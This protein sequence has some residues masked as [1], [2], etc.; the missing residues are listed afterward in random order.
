L[1]GYGVYMVGLVYK[2]KGTPY[3]SY[4]RF[5]ATCSVAIMGP[6]GIFLL[7]T[8]GGGNLPLDASIAFS[9]S[10]VISLGIFFWVYKHKT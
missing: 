8:I 9:A 10:I 5:A 1:G 2:Y 4:I 6:M 7:R 3:V